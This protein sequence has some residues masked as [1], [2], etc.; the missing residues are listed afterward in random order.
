MIAVDGKTSWP[1]QAKSLSDIS[2]G[3]VAEVE[4]VSQGGGTYL[5]TLVNAQ[6]DN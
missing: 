2:A 1:G 3:W 4:A 6:R 5:A